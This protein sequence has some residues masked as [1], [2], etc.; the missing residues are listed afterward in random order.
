MK[1]K[2]SPR[3]KPSPVAHK[4]G[5][6]CTCHCKPAS[7]RPGAVSMLLPGVRLSGAAL[8]FV[9]REAEA[10]GVPHAAVVASV[11]RVFAEWTE[12]KEARR[13]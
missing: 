7:S 2:S 9:T 6:K 5:G 10:L 3:V 1:R 8:R 11:M 13:K 12:A 4:C